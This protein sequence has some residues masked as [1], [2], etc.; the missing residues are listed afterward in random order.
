MHMDQFPLKTLNWNTVEIVVVLKFN[1]NT[2][3]IEV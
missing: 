2:E 3:N 1:S